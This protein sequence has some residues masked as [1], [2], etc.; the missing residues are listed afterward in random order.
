MFKAGCLANPRGPVE[1]TLK[2]EAGTGLSAL[3]TMV[4]SLERWLSGSEFQNI[5]LEHLRSFSAH[6]EL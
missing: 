2:S 1:L 4:C 6:L 5:R 3:W